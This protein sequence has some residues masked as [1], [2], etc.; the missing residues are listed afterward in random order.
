MPRERQLN[1]RLLAAVFQPFASGDS[2][3]ARRS[4][5]NQID[6][7]EEKKNQS[8]NGKSKQF[9]SDWFAPFDCRT[10]MMKKKPRNSWLNGYA[11]FIH[12][13][14]VNV[15]YIIFLFRFI[16]LS[17]FVEKYVRR[18]TPLNCLHPHENRKHFHLFAAESHRIRIW[19]RRLLVGWCVLVRRRCPMNF[20]CN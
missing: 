14:L 12:V 19:N 20:H 13:N 5:T 10:L 18:S 3:F 16:R 7:E 15:H 17:V 1:I 6:S 4:G 2:N 11:L 9:H 8:K